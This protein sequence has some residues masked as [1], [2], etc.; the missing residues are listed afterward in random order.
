MARKIARVTRPR[1]IG[2]HAER[3]QRLEQHVDLLLFGLAVHAIQRADACAS[4]ARCAT[5]TFARIM[6]SSMSLCAS[7]RSYM[8]TRWMRPAGVDV[9]LGLGRIELQRAALAG[10]P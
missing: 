7:L 5:A 9:E 10:A 2:R 4:R 6:H 8:Y 3:I 1:A